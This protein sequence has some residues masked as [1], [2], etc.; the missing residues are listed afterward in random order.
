M[1]VAPSRTNGFLFADLRDYTRYVESHGDRAAATLLEAYRSLVRT[2]VVDYGGAEI[3]TEGDSFYVV[4]PSASSAVQCGLAIIRSAAEGRQAGGAPIHVGIGVHAGETVATAE[5][6]VGSAVNVAARVCSQARPGELLVTDTVR[7]LTRTLL[8]VRF[9]NRTTRR[10]KGIGE[11]VVPVPR[12]AAGGGGGH[13][14]AAAGRVPREIPAGRRR[15]ADGA[16]RHVADGPADRWGRRWVPDHRRTAAT[17]TGGDGRHRFEFQPFTGNVGHLS[18]HRRG[19]PP[20]PATGRPPGCLPT[21]RGAFRAHR[22]G[23]LASLRPRACGGGRHGLVRPLRVPAGAIECPAR[24]GPGR[25]PAARRLRAGCSRVGVGRRR[26]RSTGRRLT[27]WASPV[28][29]P[30]RA[31]SA[32]LIALVSEGK[33]AFWPHPGWRR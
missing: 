23:R 15:G 29:M 11:R 22:D 3:K 16:G 17:G 18:E 8:P 19:G 6:Y 33:V 13:R 30:S 25:E 27:A 10:L 7:A 2:A 12:R 26:T 31:T 32:P 5:G 21:D 28:A 24:P 20:G 9:V 14:S 1:S 4:F